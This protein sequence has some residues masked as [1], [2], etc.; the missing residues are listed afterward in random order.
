MTTREP[1]PWP[2]IAALASMA[3]MLIGG[4]VSLRTEQASAEAKIE[5]KIS[6][7]DRRI[8]KAESGAETTTAA[9]QR[10]QIDVAGIAADIRN[11]REKLE[12]VNG[13]PGR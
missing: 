2:T 6:D 1:V 13:T 11:M 9:L 4:F 12:R 5:A 10:I 7:H 8:D 3:I